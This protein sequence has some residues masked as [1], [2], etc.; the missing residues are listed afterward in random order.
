MR[1]RY[2]L[3]MTYGRRGG[4]SQGFFTGQARQDAMAETLRVGIIGTGRAGQ[5]HAAAFSRLPGVAVT[6]LWNRTR[7]RAEKLAAALGGPDIEIYQDWRDLI[8]RGAVDIVS[9]TADPVLRQGPFAQ[10]LARQRHVLVEKPL[11]LDLPQAREM[12]SLA[13]R[14]RTVTAISFNWRYSP[15]CQT[16]WRAIREGQIGRP[17]DIR[18]EWRMRSSP[19]LRPWSQVGGSLR[20]AGSH[21]FDRVRFLTGWRFQ[22]LVCSLRSPPETNA[23]TLEKHQ[24]RAA[25]AES[26]AGAAK[27]K[28]IPSDASA[29][30]L[31][32]MTDHR[33]AAFRL[34][35]TPGEP[36]RRITIC[37]EEGTLIL[38][39]EW[40]THRPG[41]DKDKTVTL[42]N[43]VHVFRQRADDAAPVRLEIAAPDRQPPEV[44]S[45]QHTWN[46]L[47]ADFVTAVRRGDLG[48]ESVPHLPRISDGLAAQE[49]IGACE[50]S[51]AERRWVEL[52][53]APAEVSPLE[54]R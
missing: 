22:R 18:T 54:A 15:G 28:S 12:A 51:H 14:A 4:L 25:Q 29:F 19:A 21:E 38:S 8:E 1:G 48:H 43:E 47:I 23:R 7:S 6:G 9:I 52:K 53:Q 31:T 49:V 5:C 41:G 26:R 37:G 10:A 40:V 34:T 42:S 39:S 20:E 11:S 16:T 35:L 2:V 32:E 3:S 45:G 27:G 46:R 50:L 30:V 36:E 13:G 33:L 44:L 24:L 17:L